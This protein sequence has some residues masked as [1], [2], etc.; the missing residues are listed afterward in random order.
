MFHQAAAWAARGWTLL[1][2]SATTHT[3]WR[4]FNPWRW[5]HEAGG[6]HNA[7]PECTGLPAGGLRVAAR[8]YPA[9]R[10]V[11]PGGAG[12]GAGR[13]PAGAGADPAHQP[14]LLRAAGRN[15]TAR[16]S[17]DGRRALSYPI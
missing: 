15:S 10:L 1:V 2:P 16:L 9:C 17:A 5:W 7:E 12:R 11:R 8:A 4:N 13:I 6:A 14:A 3:S